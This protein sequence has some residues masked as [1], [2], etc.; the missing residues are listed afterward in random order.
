ML[1]PGPALK[2][3]SRQ[4]RAF[5]RRA[6]GILRCDVQTSPGV[7]RGVVVVNIVPAIAAM[8]ATPIKDLTS[9]RIKRSASPGSSRRR[10]GLPQRIK[11]WSLTSLQQRLVKAGGR[12][13]KH[14]RCYWLLLAESHLPRRLFGSMLLR[15]AGLSLPAG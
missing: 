14:A 2:C 15:I 9:V 5:V 10:L 8:P 4:S 6:L 13:I 7:G 12:L 1:G 11:N 3:Q